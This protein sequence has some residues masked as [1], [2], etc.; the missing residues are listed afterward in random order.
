MSRLKETPGLDETTIKAREE[1]L[2]A[3]LRACVSPSP[4]KLSL[5]KQGVRDAHQQMLSPFKDGPQECERCHK[6]FPLP[7]KLKRHTADCRRDGTNRVIH[8]RSTELPGP[9]AD[10]QPQQREWPCF[11]CKTVC[12]GCDALHRHLFTFHSNPEVRQHYNQGLHQLLG[13]KAKERCRQALMDKIRRSQFWTL[14]AAVIRSREEFSLEG[15]TFNNTYF[16]EGDKDSLGGAS[17]STSRATGFC[18]GWP[19]PSQPRST[20]LKTAIR[21]IGE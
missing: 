17:S 11:I 3:N 4:V 16:T 20:C 1:R 5:F 9:G 19:C 7:W 13:A 12:P 15:L 10:A 14:A 21:T 8:A 2:R 6:V 18:G